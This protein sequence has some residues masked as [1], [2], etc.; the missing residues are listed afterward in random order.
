MS[1]ADAPTLTPTPAPSA[2]S[3]WLAA[4]NRTPATR[5]LAGGGLVLVLMSLTRI[6]S[7]A[8]KFTA[9]TTVGTAVRLTIPILMAGMAGLYAERSGIVNIGIEGM[10][11]FGTWFGAWGAWKFDPWTGLLLGI[12]GGALGGLIHAVA[13]VRFNVDHVI[14]GVALNLLAF[15]AMRYMSELVF[16]GEKGGGIS[17]SPVQQWAIPSFNFPLLAGGKLFGWKSPDLLGWF[18][19]KGWFLISDAAGIVRGV[20]FD[21][22]WATVIGIA[23]VPLSAYVLWRTKFGLRLRSSGEAPG[24]AESLGVKIVRL[25]YIG[26]LISG[27]FAGLGGAYLS[28]V[29]SSYY[30]QGQT[31]GRGYIGLATMIFGNWRPSGVLGGALLFGYSDAIKLKDP[32]NVPALFLFVS[33]MVGILV[34]VSLVRRKMVSAITGGIAAAL[35]LIVYLTV[36]EVPD[37]LT[38]AT[39]YVITLVVLVAASQRLRPPAHAGIPWRPGD[40]H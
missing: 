30:R 20:V 26:L 5:L 25:R 17:Q 27:G 28:I 1:I 2:A 40:N 23:L 3:G 29:S 10:M 33:F 31:A 38:Q 11:I 35:F 36:K 15:N 16:T 13:T 37:S 9:S 21:V 24:A 12:I 7:D 22:S 39:P 4:I 14:S 32:E 6:I 8:D 34:I 18:E 19:E